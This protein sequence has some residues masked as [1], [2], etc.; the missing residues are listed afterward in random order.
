MSYKHGT[1]LPHAKLDDDKVRAIRKNVRGQTAKSLADM[2]GVHWRTIEKV[3][4][5][6]TWVHVR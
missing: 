5:R 1:D 4:M 2:F 3:Q 6:I